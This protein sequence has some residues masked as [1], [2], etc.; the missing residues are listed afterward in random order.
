MLKRIKK[1]LNELE[2]RLNTTKTVDFS[3]CFFEVIE[4]EHGDVNAA[5]RYASRAMEIYFKSKSHQVE[6][7][8]EKISYPLYPTIS[9]WKTTIYKRI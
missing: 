4:K 9:V 3:M 1:Y 8:K 6:I 5:V 2:Q 7:Q